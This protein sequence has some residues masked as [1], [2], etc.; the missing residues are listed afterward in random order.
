MVRTLNY[1]R[2]YLLLFVLLTTVQFPAFLFSL[3]DQHT[4]P[5]TVWVE[6]SRGRVSAEL[7]LS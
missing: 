6:C 1:Q 5:D 4:V 2:Y 3:I 7:R